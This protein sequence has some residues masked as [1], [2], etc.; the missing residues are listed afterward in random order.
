MW[1]AQH[2]FVCLS[3]KFARTERER[4]A[5]RTKVVVVVVAAAASGSCDPNSSL[6]CL[7]KRAYTPK[8][9]FDHRKQKSHALSFD[10]KSF[11][12][13]CWKRDRDVKDT[14]DK[15]K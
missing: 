13:L 9:A 4:D 8:N 12:V 3:V 14:N 1:S 11:K 7:L 15:K 10:K 5:R 6:F 2:S